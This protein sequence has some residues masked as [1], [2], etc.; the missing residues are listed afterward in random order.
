MCRLLL[1]SAILIRVKSLMICE[2][3]KHDFMY[4]KKFN[5]TFMLHNLS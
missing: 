3:T 2:M 4:N 5:T 1:P